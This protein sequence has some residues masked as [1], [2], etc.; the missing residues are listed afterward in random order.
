MGFQPVLTIFLFSV[1]LISIGCAS[2][3]TS[4]P[5]TATLIVNVEAKP[6]PGVKSIHRV[7]VYDTPLE[8]APKGDYEHV[9]YEDLDDIIVWLEPAKPM[10]GSALGAQDVPIY[11]NRPYPIDHPIAVGQTIVVHN[12]TAK[13]QK[14]Y[15]VS[16]NNEFDLPK[17][18]P[19][20]SASQRIRAAGP[21]EILSDLTHEPVAQLYAVPSALYGQVH[22]GMKMTFINL[23][24][25]A[26]KIE[27]YHPR[28]PG[29]EAQV[30]LAA[31][32]TTSATV[33]VG[34]TNLTNR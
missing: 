23:P 33:S 20:Q 27:S 30:N 13:A 19:G 32:Q 28:L 29:S 15:C 7:Y 24:P 3:P 34:V 14:F 6:K 5:G 26:C 12:H 2:H 9:D 8:N 16:D 31:N 25:G 11:D 22:S 1:L 18:E 10:N 17:L 21:I 4:A